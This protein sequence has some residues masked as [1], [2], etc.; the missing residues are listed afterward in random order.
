[1]KRILFISSNIHT[2]WG[3]SELLWYKTAIFLI[4]QKAKVEVAVIARKWPHVPHHIQEIVDAGGR[5]YDLPIMPTTPYE[6]VKAKLK[7]PVEEQ[8]RFLLKKISPDL[9]VHSMGKSFEG[10]DWMKI[11]HELAVPYV[12]IIHLASELQWP[13]NDE[14]DAY[15][16]GYEN[17]RR[18]YFVSQ[19]NKEMVYRQLGMEMVNSAIVRNP[20]SVSREILPYPSVEEG[21]YCALP[22]QLVPIHKGQDILFEV[23]AQPKWKQRAFHLNLYGTGAYSKSM[24][25]YGRYLGLENVH[26]KGYAKNI[27]EVWRKN[28]LL[29]M[30]SRMEGLPLTLIEAM[31]CGRPAIV[32]EIAGMKE[33][34]QDGQTGFL[35]KS[36][37]PEALD[38]AMERAWQQRQH[39]QQMGLLA[40]ARTKEL[41]PF[42]PVE[43]FA[44][45]LLRQV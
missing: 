24:S 15:R 1:M 33:C 9:L 11:A 13:D 34:V 22:A 18:N 8:K 6:Y 7:R 3:G 26:F 37:H 41:I 28:H 17:A 45:S 20:I 29:I 14:V 23:L 31:S 19:A 2:P 38:E 4:A 43:E 42:E 21:Y 35:A 40:A 5:I 25:Y 30:S 10:R 44:D 36:A 27:E 12:N 32:T 16:M 39:W